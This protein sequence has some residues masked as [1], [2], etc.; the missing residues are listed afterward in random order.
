M[1]IN[2]NINPYYD[3]FDESKNYH[4]ILFKPGF[5]VQA[6]ELTQLQTIIQD[7]IQKFGNHI[8]KHGSVVIPGNSTADLGAQYVKLQ[9]VNVNL[10]TADIEGKVVVGSTTQ[11]RALVRKYVPADGVNPAT[12][13]VNYLRG[14]SVSSVFNDAETLT[15]EGTS[16]T[17]L[18]ASS[19]ATGVGSLAFVNDGV[20]YVNG[21]FVS[22]FKQSVVISRYTST[23]SAH[24]ILK[25]TDSIV[26]TEED[27]TLVD[28]A[29]GSY[30]YS[31]P[32][33]DRYKI[34]LTLDTLPYGSQITDDVVELMRYNDGV[35]EEHSRYPKYNE[36]EKSLARRTYDESG[37]YVVN[38]LTSEI[39]EHKK[40]DI[41]GGIDVNGSVDKFVSTVAS[42]K[43]YIGGFEVEKI[44]DTNLILDKGRTADHIKTKNVSTNTDFGQYLYVADLS[45]ALPF[46]TPMKTLTVY[47]ATTSGS[48]IGTLQ[49][50]AID[51][52]VY[53]D[54]APNTSV[55]KLY[56]NNLVLNAGKTVE[57]IGRLTYTVDSVARSMN[58]LHKL[59]VSGTNKDFVTSE[60][61]T[62]GQTTAKK[63]TV[64]KWL[65]GPS[66]LYVTKHSS[67]I[68][69]PVQGNLITG[70]TSGATGGSV[71]QKTV[72]V[73]TADSAQIFELPVDTVNKVKNASNLTDISYKVFKN[74]TIN[75]VADG[76]GSATVDGTIETPIG[77][78]NT[79]FINS[80][81]LISLGSVSITG[82]NTVTVSG[83]T[84]GSKVYGVVSVTKTLSQKTKTKTST[85]DAAVTISAGVGT[86]TKSDVYRITA[87]T[88]GGTDNLANFVLD[89][90]QKDYAYLN[91][92]ITWV[93]SGTAPAS[94]SVSYEYFN[95]SSGDYFTADSYTTLGS[96][97]LSLIPTY[98]SKSSGIQYDLR[99]CIDFRQRQNGAVFDSMDVVQPQSFIT[100]SVQYFVPRVDLIFMN[101]DG[102]IGVVTGDPS[103][104]PT[105]GAQPTGTI[106]LSTVFVPAYTKEIKDI[107][108]TPVMN[109]VYTMSDIGKLEDRVYNLEQ[110]TLLSQAETALIN[111]DVLDAASGKSRYKSG[112][113]VENFNDP[114]MISDAFSSEFKCM[115]KNSMLY[116]QS[117]SVDVELTFSSSE[118]TDYTNT[119]GLITLPYTEVE[120]TRQN[121]STRVTN[122][123]PFSVFAWR[124]QMV[125][126]P[127]VDNYVDIEYLPTIFEDVTVEEV[128]IRRNWKEWS[129][130]E[131][132]VFVGKRSIPISTITS[133]KYVN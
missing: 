62:N 9:S 45:G 44:A 28:P 104:T 1:P 128:S 21:K 70:E 37:D 26:T 114:N 96:S 4:Q 10:T 126:N 71:D 85:T 82:G 41:N 108:V 115:Y 130:L 16:N 18:S 25:I 33:A 92:K 19:T 39:K 48:A 87:I 69:V 81:G 110:Y 90:G 117:E 51:M 34:E 123:N 101:K 50:T 46:D 133:I 98:A 35:L 118:S 24:V 77:N 119:N 116:P 29:Q 42:G 58:V 109:K 86:L 102:R 113:L 88:S 131:W 27:E 78:E 105:V 127:S 120:L 124:G 3:D 36:L 84:P 112:Y 103:D 5:A 47:D 129:P 11:L 93:G 52:E 94:V 60:L 72:I 12:I 99:N 65:S 68:S 14:G 30:N 132:A 17:L 57:S 22:V 13:Y 31:A 38:G 55:F 80:S 6:R 83:Q 61:I 95:H 8:F 43:A 79:F 122:V 89:N 76:T 74:I 54:A 40:V 107:A 59:V 7:Q 73:S 91:G 100:T 67:T 111:Y 97:Y 125:L 106:A 64:Y 56:I 66:I 23:P 49:V 121:L 63:A 2:T 15:I 20:F 32:G 75:I 53:D